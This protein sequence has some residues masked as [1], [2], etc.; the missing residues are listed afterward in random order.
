MD[1]IQCHQSNNYAAACCGIKHFEI[2]ATVA[3]NVML[4]MMTFVFRNTACQHSD[5]AFTQVAGAVLL[6]RRI[7]HRIH[8]IDS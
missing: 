3:R 4:A 5:T 1:F 8:Q 6:H 2:F 7:N